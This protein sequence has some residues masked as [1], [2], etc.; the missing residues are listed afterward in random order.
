VI[1][2][3]SNVSIYD[4]VAVSVSGHAFYVGY[5]SHDNV[6]ERNLGSQTKTISWS[7]VLSGENDY[8]A[9]AFFSRFPPNSFISNVAAGNQVH[10]YYFSNSDWMVRTEASSGFVSL[11][12]YFT[13]LLIFLY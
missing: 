2:G 7:N 8:D 11:R 12:T 6:F 9:S 13:Y 1:E 4:N 10:G 5:Q 3:S